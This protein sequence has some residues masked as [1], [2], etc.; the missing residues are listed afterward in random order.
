MTVSAP[1]L[2]L[3]LSS[4]VTMPQE[5]PP[6]EAAPYGLRMLVVLGVSSSHVAAQALYRAVTGNVRIVPELLWRTPK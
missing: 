4:G 5:C 6:R 2:D 3:P 1:I